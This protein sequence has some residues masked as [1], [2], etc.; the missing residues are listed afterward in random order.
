VVDLVTLPAVV[1]QLRD[2]LDKA[3]WEALEVLALEVIRQSAVDRETRRQIL[4]LQESQAE[5]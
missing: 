2:Q 4:C 1:S 3:Q 5:G